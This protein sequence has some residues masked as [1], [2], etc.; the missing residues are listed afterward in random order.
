MQ[1]LDQWTQAN[2]ID[3]MMF[4]FA[5]DDDDGWEETADRIK[6]AIRQ[7]VLDSYRN[8]QGAAQRPP[9]RVERRH[10]PAQAH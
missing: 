6:K 4:S 5:E 2:I 10:V 9:V 3:P 8:G 1:E 7:K